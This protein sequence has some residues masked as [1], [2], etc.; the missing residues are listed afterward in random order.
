MIV[1]AIIAIFLNIH[2]GEFLSK[3][4]VVVFTQNLPGNTYFA[5]LGIYLKRKILCQFPNMGGQA[6]TWVPRILRVLEPR[7]Q[8]I[9]EYEHSYRGPK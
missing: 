8:N 3:E 1:I 6:L 7:F 4:L 5:Y 2:G 9:Q